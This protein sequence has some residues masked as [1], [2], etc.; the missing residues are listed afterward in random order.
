MKL[1][2][3]IV[4]DEPKA[5][6]ILE[7]YTIKTVQLELIKSFRDPIEAI[8]FINNTNIDL[9]ILD[10]N[11]P[12]ITGIQLIKIIPKKILYIF[13]TA[14]AEHAIYSYELQVIDYLLK[15]I[16][17]DRFY[18]AIIKAY[19]FYQFKKMG[20][21][22]L[23]PSIQNQ[24][25]ILFLKSGTLIHKVNLHEILYFEKENVYFTLHQVSGKKIIIRS[26]FA[27]L[28][29][30]LP[31]NLFVRVHKSYLISIQHI[32]HIRADEVTIQKQK[33]PISE[34]YKDSFFST[35]KLKINSNLSSYSNTDSIDDIE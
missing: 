35:I 13:A 15:P 30:I 17:F 33:I 24:S 2:T 34:T 18:Q 29:E 5:I 19:D 4:D 21:A 31:P 22:D 6:E 25:D 14:H 7:R 10:I 28:I 9:V 3:I 11:M 16:L 32:V 1:R 27:S 20:T 12:N 8:D 23:T 26:N